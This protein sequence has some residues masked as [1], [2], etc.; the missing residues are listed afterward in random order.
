MWA[1]AT[2]LIH[3]VAAGLML[4]LGCGD[5]KGTGATSDRAQAPPA[6]PATRTVTTADLCSL[7]TEEEAEAI[8]AKKLE[9]PQRQKGGDCWYL[10]EGGNDFGDVELILSVLPTHLRSASDFDKFIAEQV[11]DLNENMRKAG[12]T[13]ST[14]EKVR[15]VGAPAYYIDPSLFVFNGGRVLAIAAERPKAVAIAAK[16]LPRFK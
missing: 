3:S 16:A 1:M 15:E 8:L 9:P 13:E 4:A 10:R 2:L 6:N 12:G 14:P 11:K 5:S 7:L